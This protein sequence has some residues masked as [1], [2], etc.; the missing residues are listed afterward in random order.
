MSSCLSRYYLSILLNWTK[1]KPSSIIWLCRV[2]GLE[3]T[4][5]YL[6]VTSKTFSNYIEYNLIK[7]LVAFSSHNKHKMD[8]FCRLFCLYV[9]MECFCYPHE[10]INGVKWRLLTDAKSSQNFTIL[11]SLKE[12]YSMVISRLGQS[13]GCLK[14]SLIIK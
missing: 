5:S 2:E 1:A 4:K 8:L 9:Y 6:V 3:L 12:Y 14:N 10:I 11:L 7:A 13:Q